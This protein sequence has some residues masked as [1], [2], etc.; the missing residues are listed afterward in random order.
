MI[1]VPGESQRG[2]G[3]RGRATQVFDEIVQVLQ[4]PRSRQAGGVLGREK[5]DFGHILSRQSGSHLGLTILEG[6]VLDLDFH[7]RMR[8]LEILN[9]SRDHLLLPVHSGPTR[10][11]YSW[12]HPPHCRQAP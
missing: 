10:T 2:A 5:S 7:T 9:H 4:C 6:D 1:I 3:E 12:F 11:G 8:G